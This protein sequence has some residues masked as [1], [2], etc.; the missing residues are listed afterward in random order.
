M[1]K[2][3][4]DEDAFNRE[5]II[6]KSI[7]EDKGY[8][9]ESDHG[10]AYSMQYEDAFYDVKNWL[11]ANGYEGDLEALGAFEGVAVYG[12][13]DSN[14]ISFQEMHDKLLEEAKSQI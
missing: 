14:R 9:L 5:M 4:K 3:F 2:Y 12:L 11:I 1:M 13:Y 6:F 7:L 10:Y 8:V